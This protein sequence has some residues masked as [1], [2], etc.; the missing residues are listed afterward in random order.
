MSAPFRAIGVFLVFGASMAAL[1][2]LTLLW[3]GTA[4]DRAWALNP[5][6]YAQLSTRPRLFGSMF[7]LLSFALTCSAVGWF[8]MRRWGWGLAVTI[9]S[10]Q[11]AGDFGNLL[12]G[13]LLRGLT[14]FLIAGGLLVYLLRPKVRKAFQ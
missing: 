9:I 6:A 12:R 5:M 3:P 7:V 1:A 10:I 14:G 11:V 13:D 2:A 4:L 8:R